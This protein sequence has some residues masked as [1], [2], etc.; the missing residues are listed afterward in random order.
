MSTHLPL[1]I[2]LLHLLLTAAYADECTWLGLLLC[3]A[4]LL[5]TLQLLLPAT[6]HQIHTWWRAE[7]PTFHKQ[8]S[9]KTYKGVSMQDFTIKLSYIK[10][11]QL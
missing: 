9:E 4:L 1:Q 5:H 6:A 8:K 11:L 7:K 2:E 10:R 3:A